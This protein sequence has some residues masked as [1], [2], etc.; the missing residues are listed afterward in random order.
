[1]FVPPGLVD[2]DGLTHP[3]LIPRAHAEGGYS[4]PDFDHTM[5]SVLSLATTQ[6][7]DPATWEMSNLT[8][9]QMNSREV[10]S[11][12]ARFFLVQS[13]APWPCDVARLSSAHA[14]ISAR[15][16]VAEDGSAPRAE[17]ARAWTERIDRGF[18]ELRR[19][20]SR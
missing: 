17:T 2:F 20:V 4:L 14:H 7:L 5:P 16:P 18:S 13:G 3:G 15:G 1:M 12:D 6:S 9:M 8:T 11:E 10:L 19:L